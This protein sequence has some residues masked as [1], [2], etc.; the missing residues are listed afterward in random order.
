MRDGH[1]AVR[2]RAPFAKASAA[3]LVSAQRINPLVCQGLL[4]GTALVSDFR[5]PAAV[6]GLDQP[7]VHGLRRCPA[8][9]ARWRSRAWVFDE[10]VSSDRVK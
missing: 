2:D 4:G 9:L 8:W 6:S 7:S 10:L 1:R 3:Y 5:E